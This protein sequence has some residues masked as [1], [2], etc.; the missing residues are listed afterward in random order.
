[1]ERRNLL[2][3]AVLVLPTL[4]GCRQEEAS[5]RETP[6]A[7]D[8]SVA[9]S[10]EKLESSKIEVATVDEHPVDDVVTTSGRVTFEDVKVAHIV[11]P[12]NGRIVSLNANLGERVKRGDTLATIRSPDIGQASAD[13]SKARAGLMAAEHNYK[14]KKDLFD[15]EAAS[16]AEYEAAQDTYRQAK[17][18][19]DRAEQKARLLQAGSLDVVTQGFTLTSPID[20]EVI[21]RQVSPGAEL[22]GEYSA[23]VSNELFTV[24][25]LDR[26]WVVADVYELD[27][28]RVQVGAKV[29]VSVVAYPDKAFEG[30]VDW[31]PGTLDSSTRTIR[32]RCTFDNP[33]WLLKPE[34]YATVRISVPSHSA[35][36]VPR[37]AVVRMGEQAVVF[38]EHE[39]L[40]GKLHFEREPVDV[41]DLGGSEPLVRV[42]HG[43]EKGMR[44][45][46]RG[47]TT[48]AGMM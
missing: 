40:D 3:L 48:I 2:A 43:L 21:A 37:S 30:K 4:T 22:Q 11:S 46:T 17:A 41:D 45:V 35:L 32:V 33:G 5:A 10:P 1:M 18:E 31:V 13:L 24:G 28:A 20:G 44:V 27:L 39:G 15:A 36:A 7:N 6:S 29:S 34:M 12:V 38:V 8:G 25:E 9:L 23:G 47:A 26:V 42:E 16:A 19:K 14:R